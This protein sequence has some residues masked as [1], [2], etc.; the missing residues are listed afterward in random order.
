MAELTLHAVSK[1]YASGVEALSPVTLEVRDGQFVVLVGPSG[2]GKSTL[3]RIIAGLE[4]PTSGSISLDSV[5]VA[6]LPAKERDVAM[7][8]QS[9]ALYPHFTVRQNLEFG[10]KMRGMREADRI[11]EVNSVADLLHLS[12]LLDRRPPE[13]SGGQQQRV[14][15]GRAIVRRPKLFLMDEP[16][17][18][19]DATLR[20]ST[21]TELLRLHRRLRA[22]TIFVTHD[23]VEAMSMA[24]VLVVLKDGKVQ[25][26]GAPLDVYKRPA[27]RFV[28]Q[29][30]GSPPMNLLETTLTDTRTVELAGCRLPFPPG[31]LSHSDSVTLGLRAEHICLQSDKDQDG[32]GWI[33]SAKVIL[34]EPLGNEVLATCLVG[35]QD[36]VIRL[37]ASSTVQVGQEVKL[38]LNLEEAV[39][40]D[41]SSKA[42]ID[43]DRVLTSVQSGR[44]PE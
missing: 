12:G 36:V 39:W 7:V 3:L 18:N 34:L 37:S 38:R 20:A 14:A 44:F 22:T 42:V 26:I 23:Q 2:C 27:N 1:V 6:H 8:F 25:Q 11:R 41:N 33:I 29:F 19:L 35:G 31:T 32:A 15:L 30:I 5:P 40:F 17:S 13:L 4:Q 9:Y 16:F 24:D 21:R 43:N 10:L 28:A